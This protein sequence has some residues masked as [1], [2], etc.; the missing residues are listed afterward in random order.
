MGGWARPARRGADKPIVIY[1][2]QAGGWL[3]GGGSVDGDELENGSA[4]GGASVGAA[5]DGGGGGWTALCSSRLRLGLG[6]QS[7]AGLREVGSM[8]EVGSPGERAFTTPAAA[9]LS[10]R[11]DDL[12]EARGARASAAD[13]ARHGGLSSAGSE[14]AGERHSA[15]PAAAADGEGVERAAVSP[16]ANWRQLSTS[17]DDDDDD[18]GYGGDADGFLSHT[19]HT[20]AAASLGGLG[21]QFARGSAQLGARDA[22]R[23]SWVLRAQA[24]MRQ[25][26]AADAQRAN[27]AVAAVAQQP[28]PAQPGRAHDAAAASTPAGPDGGHGG[29]GVPAIAAIGTVDTPASRARS[30]SDSSSSHS[31][32]APTPATPT[33]FLGSGVGW[34]RVDSDAAADVKDD[35]GAL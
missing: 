11:W 16:A 7:A 22:S 29:P 23:P 6:A 28:D 27:A 13:T 25:Q 34:M 4:S 3:A 21:S 20:S 14:P 19:R 24:R 26:R 35:D 15:E 18:D 8:G 1:D 30:S 31:Q 2:M 9:R 33:P 17:D 10:L 5:G 32:G 12:K